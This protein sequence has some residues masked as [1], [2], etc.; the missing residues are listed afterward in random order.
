VSDVSLLPPSEPSTSPIPPDPT[1]ARAKSRRTLWIILGSVVGV[2]VLCIVI[3]ALVIGRTIL[4]VSTE[5]TAITPV[6]DRFMR[7]MTQH[8]AQAA[9]QLFSSRAQRQTPL[10]DL[11]T[12]LEGPNYTLFDGYQSVTIDTTNLTSAINTNPDVPQ[13]SVA[14]VNGTVTYA[15]GVTGSFRATLEKEDG[16]WRLFFINVTVP[17]SKLKPAT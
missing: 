16:E 6:I 13:G 5:Q 1:P 2:L 12:L 9:Y 4:S 7:A 14:M 11:T 3:A 10:A 17:P 8:D 15:G